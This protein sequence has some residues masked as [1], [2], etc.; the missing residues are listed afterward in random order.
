M[1]GV[2]K[3]GMWV[4][5]ISPVFA[6]GLSAERYQESACPWLDLMKCP[7]LS[8]YLTEAEGLVQNA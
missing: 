6:S 7:D 5:L 3:N 1:W 4:I 2:L 8:K